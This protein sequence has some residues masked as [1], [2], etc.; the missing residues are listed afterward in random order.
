MVGA[1]TFSDYPAAAKDLPR[2]SDGFNPNYEQVVALKP[3]LVLAAGITAPEVIKKLEDLN[4]T[5]LVVGSDRTTLDGISSE[6]EMVAMAL[7]AQEQAKPVLAGMEQKLKEIKG[8][9]ATAKSTPRVYW[10]LDATDPG[11]PFAPGPGSFVDDMIK[12]A[13]GESV[14]ANAKE[15]FAQFNAEEIIKA[16]P[17]I[18]ILSDA[19]YGIA[20]ES[21]GERP[22]WGVISAVKNNQVYPIDDNLVSRPGPRVVDGLEAAAKLIH[23]EVF[24]AASTNTGTN[25]DPFAYC[26]AVGTI[27]APDARYTGP[28]VPEA[29][30]KGLQKAFGVPASDP[31]DPF[32]QNSIWRC[33]GGKVYAC[34]FG[35]NLA[36]D[37]K[38][39]TDNK[40]TSGESDYCK[41]NPAS[42]FIPA[43]ITGHDSVYNWSCKDGVALAGEVIIKP[44]A[45]GYLSN[46]WYEMS[47]N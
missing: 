20:P 39:N 46:I 22:G 40:P 23:P 15:P 7:S 31:L 12:L 36:C 45:Q 4:L 5:V 8:K 18:I 43:Y 47:P 3:D 10:E 44:D 27:N 13:G 11:K 32:L 33:M 34:N 29:V 37:A 17:E 28:K 19:A 25:A 41:Q 26:A 35:A 16:N 9:V 2:V 24:G 38:A 6:I 30:A 14:T 42:D 21:V 1:D